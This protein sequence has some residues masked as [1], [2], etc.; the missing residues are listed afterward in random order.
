MS[1][2]HCIIVMR[3]GLFPGWPL[4]CGGEGLA[5]NRPPGAATV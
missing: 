3:V 2:L 5:E 4:F 1:P